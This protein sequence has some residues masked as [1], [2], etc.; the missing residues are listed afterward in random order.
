[1]S[2]CGITLKTDKNIYIPRNL[3]N[4]NLLV[5]RQP[6]LKLVLTTM[7]KII[8]RNFIVGTNQLK[9]VVFLKLAPKTSPLFVY[10]VL[11]RLITNTH[12]SKYF[13]PTVKIP[14]LSALINMPN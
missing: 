5:E 4:Q 13:S 12:L 6:L 9:T 1:M 2:C 14:L 8:N 3:N 10:F 7:M 11:L